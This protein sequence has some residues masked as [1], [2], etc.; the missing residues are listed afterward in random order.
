MTETTDDQNKKIPLQ[1]G[2]EAAKSAQEPS[3]Q[4]ASDVEPL[5][6]VRGL[7]RHFPITKGL[8]KRQV[9]A[10]QAVDGIDFDVRPGRRS[11]SSASPAAVSRRWA[12]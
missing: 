6:R 9:G 10:V 5:L 1:K 12:G 8:L 2:P 3:A 4:D 7:V 11:A